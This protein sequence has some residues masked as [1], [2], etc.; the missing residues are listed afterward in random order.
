MLKLFVLTL[1]DHL[2]Q[3]VLLNVLWALAVLPWIA[4][5]SAV[6]W[7]AAALAE[8]SGYGFIAGIGFV[9][10]ATLIVMSPP[11]LCVF[12]AAHAWTT[13]DDTG[14]AA[15]WRMARPLLW[16]AQA[17]GLLA[18]L[19]MALL[20]GNALFYQTW[21]GWLGLALSGVMLWLIAAL[22]LLLVLLFPVL[23]DA[24]ERPLHLALRQCLLLLL[25][26][27]RLSATTGLACALCLVLGAGSGAGI[28][29]GAIPATALAA[30]LGVRV[31]LSRY[32][33]AAPVPD[34][35]NLRDVLRPW[36]A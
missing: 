26:N 25:G 27:L 30:T 31:M 34:Q 35:R 6:T 22:M 7:L 3:V 8:G 11:T 9:A 4:A 23:L 32:G 36:Q 29:L 2:G 1:Y 16:R 12:A 5:G 19:V 18:A 13:E 24:P 17:A 15:V 28:I 14:A 20:V 10:A 33:G 21:A